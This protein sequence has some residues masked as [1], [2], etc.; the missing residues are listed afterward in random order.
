LS[1]LNLSNKDTGHQ[2]GTAVLASKI[3]ELTFWPAGF[4]RRSP[5][6]QRGARCGSRSG[7]TVERWARTRRDPRGDCSRRWYVLCRR[8]DYLCCCRSSS[9][10]VAIEPPRGSAELLDKQINSGS[11]SELRIP[12]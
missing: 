10:A 11:R 12:P 1:Q 7:S 6:C 9:P 5:G 8:R 4:P 3:T 2:N